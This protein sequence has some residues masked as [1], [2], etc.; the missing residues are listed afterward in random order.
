[1]FS[2]SSHPSTTWLGCRLAGW[3]CTTPHDT[4]A[5]PRSRVWTGAFQTSKASRCWMAPRANWMDMGIH[6]LSSS[7]FL[8]DSRTHCV[9]IAF[10]LIVKPVVVLFRVLLCP[11]LAVNN[12]SFNTTDASQFFAQQRLICSVCLSN[13]FQKCDFVIDHRDIDQTP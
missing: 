5:R 9:L 10:R 6:W 7:F 2:L 8:L 11:S 1:M 4:Q 13:A 12:H 3:V